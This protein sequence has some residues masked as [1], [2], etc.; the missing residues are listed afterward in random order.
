MDMRLTSNINEVI[1]DMDTKIHV[2]IPQALEDSGEDMLAILTNETR[3]YIP[4]EHRLAA[5]QKKLSTGRLWSSWGIAVRRTSNEDYN[6]EDAIAEIKVVKGR[7]ARINVTVGTK[8][9]YAR[10]ANDGRPLGQGR[11]AY[12]F[13]EKGQQDAERIIMR[14]LDQNINAALVPIEQQKQSRQFNAA[15]QKRDV[16]GRFGSILR[17]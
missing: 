12:H 13:V 5:G 16:L 9:P 2:T 7:S 8:V 15:R 11:T 10:Y 1:Q 6:P 17:R 4:S 3:K 14:K